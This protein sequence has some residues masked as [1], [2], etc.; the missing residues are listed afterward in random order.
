ME[1]L[2]TPEKKIT[3]DQV[4]IAT[5]LAKERD[6]DQFGRSTSFADLI[7]DVIARLQDL[8]PKQQ[9]RLGKDLKLEDVGLVITMNGQTGVL[10]D[11]RLRVDQDRRPPE[12]MTAVVNGRLFNVVRGELYVLDFPD[13]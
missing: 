9:L 10:T 2:R 12:P 6:Y 11:L 4:R 8:K 1:N 5:E 7:L 13:V 3:P